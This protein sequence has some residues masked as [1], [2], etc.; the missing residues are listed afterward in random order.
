M[1]VMFTE[2]LSQ[3]FNTSILQHHLISGESLVKKLII[4]A[5]SMLLS[6]SVMASDVESCASYALGAP[7]LDG[8]SA[9]A[10]S[11]TA[12]VAGDKSAEVHFTYYFTLAPIKNMAKKMAAVVTDADCKILGITYFNASK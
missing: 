3:N 10:K 2:A 1:A 5:V 6:I 7:S 4:V 11:Y 8:Y 12:D 9:E